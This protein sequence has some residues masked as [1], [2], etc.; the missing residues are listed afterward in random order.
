M[1]LS[2]SQCAA[3]KLLVLGIRRAAIDGFV[4]CCVQV[5]AGTGDLEVLRLC[6]HLRSRVGVGYGYVLY[7]SH[8][9]I[10]MAL[11]LLFMGGGRYTLSSDPEAIAAM[12]CA[13]FPKFPLHSND[14]R[15]D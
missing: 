9:A 10:S 1:H 15:F 14:N 5:M 12:L 7:G 11:G 2:D 6:R 13:F 3:I 8:M 4:H